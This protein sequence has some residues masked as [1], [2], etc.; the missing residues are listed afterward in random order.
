[1]KLSHV[2]L[3][4]LLAAGYAHSQY[5]LPPKEIVD[6]IDAPPTPFVSVSPGGTSMLLVESQAHPSVSL[7]ARPIHRIA[8]LRI[9]AERHS[10]QHLTVLTGLQVLSLPHAATKRIALPAGAVIGAPVWSNDGS[11][12]AFTRDTDTDLQLWWADVATGTPQQV[13]GVKVNDVLGSPMQWMSDHRRLLVRTVPRKLGAPPTLPRVPAGPNVDETSGRV[14]RTATFQDLLRSS[15]DEALF[16]HYGTTQL[17]VVD[18]ITGASKP[19]GT[20]RLILSATFSPDEKFLLVNAAKRPFSYRVPYPS[21]ARTT[22]VWGAD[23]T[24][25]R[26]VAD[27]PVA[28]DVPTQGVPRGLRAAEWQAY[29]GAT[30][31]WVD[32]LDEGDP[33]KK[34]P[35]RDRVLRLSTP[36]DGE[37][38]EVM[39]VQ[40]R[41]MGFTWAGVKDEALVFEYDRDRRWRTTALVTLTDPERTRKVLFDLSVNDAYSNPGSPVQTTLPN[42][43]QVAVREGD[44]IY[45]SGRGASDQGDRPF[46]DRFN[47]G[48]KATERLFQSADGALE[49]FVAFAGRDRGAF[50]VRSESSTDVPNYFL[51]NIAGGGRIRLTSFQDPAPQLT[52]MSRQL[53]KYR[54]SDG[55]PLSGTLYLPIG[56][57]PGARLPLLIWAYPLEFSDPATAGQVRTSPHQFTFFRGTTPLFFVTQGYAV[58]MD[59]T[60]P[61][62]GDPETMNN[63]FIEQIVGAAKAAIDTLDAM[64]VIDPKRVAV[65]GH[66]YGAF[67][68]ANLLAHSDLFAAG[69]A[70]SGAYNRTLTPF[71]FQSERRSFWEAKEIYLKVSP[72]MYADKINEPLL[73]I[74]GEADNNTGTFPIQSERLFQAI[75]GNGGT[76]K[77]VILPYESH[78]YS[79]RESVLHTLAEMLEWGE[80]FVKMKQ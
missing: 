62:V 15:H 10:R 64:G 69:I 32:A 44:W 16:E 35:H 7:L 8:G 29:H 75:S 55:V 59:A 47:L 3:L 71:G 60:M 70:R 72:F 14:S 67:M 17:V 4:C 6:I 42:G 80:R 57:V 12:I 61:V 48:T 50:I 46:L 25:A 66:S 52:G 76:A 74:H 39:K 51:R 21:F 30:V 49:Q 9:D 36:F 65:S 41:L 54:R 78:G 73:L 31:V 18:V 22:E 37:P 19:L 63:T 26:L 27:L 58:L 5:K 2:L 33:M 45:L 28:D 1:M 20:A 38:T 53:L 13:K 79:G 34:V 68:T 24:L 23:G 56:T 77:L 43:D 40:H 11:K